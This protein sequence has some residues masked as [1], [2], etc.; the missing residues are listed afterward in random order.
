MNCSP[1]GDIEGH[2]WEAGKEIR[3]RGQG[4]GGWLLVLLPLKSRDRL[5]KGGGQR[6]LVNFTSGKTKD[7]SFGKKRRGI[8]ASTVGEV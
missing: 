3:V 1:R 6:A 2:W 5:H 4:K 7:K 8:Q